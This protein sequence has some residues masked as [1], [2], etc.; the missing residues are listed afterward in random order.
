MPIDYYTSL[1]GQCYD[2]GWLQLVR[3]S[4]SNIMCLKVLEF[5]LEKRV[6]TL[7]SMGFLSGD[8]FFGQTVNVDL[9]YNAGK[10]LAC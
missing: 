4:F 9:L 8:L 6:R 2:L 10:I 1:W 3:S 5:D 7:N